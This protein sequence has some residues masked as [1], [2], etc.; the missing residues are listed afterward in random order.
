MF[1]PQL[2]CSYDSFR[3]LY[4]LPEDCLRLDWAVLRFKGLPKFPR[5]LKGSRGET[6]ARPMKGRWHKK[7][8]GEMGQLL[9]KLSRGCG[10]KM[11]RW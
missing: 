7:Q 11:A 10:V 2:S 3:M 1:D 8:I 6:G 4:K 5:P 9:Q